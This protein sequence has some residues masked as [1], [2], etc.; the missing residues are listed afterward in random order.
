MNKATSQIL[1]K[2]PE[3]F[4]GKPKMEALI[5]AF[6]VELD[7]LQDVFTEL[8]ELRNLNSAIGKQLDLAGSIVVL[9]RAEATA[10]ADRVDFDVM[11]D[12]RYRLFLKYKALRNTNNCTYPE[13]MEA[14]QLLYDAK[15]VYYMEPDEKPAYFKVMVG[16][17]FDES[18]MS[19]L[20]NTN[21]TVKPGGVSVDLEFFDME[22]F[23][24]RD[25]NRDALGFGVGKFLYVYIPKERSE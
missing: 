17:Q 10:F 21:T 6:A 18:L 7:E 14:C 12:D 1:N 20:K 8:H 3:Q 15:K 2:L 16:G 22:F 19:I 13:L 23:G 24:F 9:S 5:N 25:L 11:D 4:K